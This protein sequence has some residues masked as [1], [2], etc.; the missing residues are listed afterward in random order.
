MSD[1]LEAGLLQEGDEVDHEQTR[2]GTYHPATI[3]ADGSLRM[4]GR[5]YTSPSSALVDA[6]G[7][8]RN[9]WTDWRVKRTGESL[10]DLRDRMRRE[11]LS[12]DF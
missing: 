8:S 12:L 6:T 5:R 9:G 3:E 11:H 4:D 1:L 2:M 10:A 7:A